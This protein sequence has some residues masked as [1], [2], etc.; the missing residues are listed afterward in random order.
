MKV[1]SFRTGQSIS[2][3][4]ISYKI[5]RVHESGS[6]QLERAKDLAI[7]ARSKSDLL[8]LLENGELE[9]LSGSNHGERNE[10][11]G[12][13]IEYDLS[14]F[15]K[16]QQRM[17][18][19]KY[20]YVIA[21]HRAKNGM[22]TATDLEE[23][24][25]AVAQKL[26]DSAPPTPNTVY[27]WWSKWLF[28]GQDIRCLVP[29]KKK[30]QYVYH[31]F[32]GSVEKIVFQVIEDEYLNREN[33]TLE[34]AYAELET[35]LKELNKARE[36]PLA[37]PSRATFFRIA[38]RI[39]RFDRMAAKKG[40]IAAEK[41]FR[42]T[43]K[44]VVTTSILER[45]E[46]DHTRLDVF[47]VDKVSGESI[48]RP[49]L[50]LLIDVHSRMIFGYYIG[51]EPPSELSVMLA[52]RNGIL[53][54]SNL[55]GRFPELVN[56]WNCY[57]IP[58]TLVSDN[59]MEFHSLQLRRMCAELNIEILFCPKKSP[60]YKG[61]VERVQGTLNREVCHVL[62]GTSFGS[63]GERGDYASQAMARVTLDELEE[64]I[65]QWIVDIYH[66][67]KHGTTKKPPAKVWDG[68]LAN[69][70]PMLPESRDALD[71]VLAKEWK[72]T[73][74]H[75]GIVFQGLRYNAED[76]LAIRTHPDFDGQV[77]IRVNPKNLG[78]IWV[79]DDLNGDCFKVYCT[80][81]EYANNLSLIQ[82]KL[83]RR[84]IQKTSASLVDEDYLMEAKRRF[85]DKVKLMKADK[86]T[87]NRTRAARYEE[88]MEEQR[89]ESCVK[90][91][92][93]SNTESALDLEM[94]Y[95]PDYEAL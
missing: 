12:A 16:E 94:D 22:R 81:F 66:Q 77:R 75:D 37:I 68:D 65:T 44:G 86:L 24:I 51:F 55:R 18:F 88:G 2:L 8:K 82:H 69:I 67:R 53:P 46:V 29:P 9:F 61:C 95:I 60:Q 19:R 34:S 14:C 64:L 10:N 26:D 71:L 59:A 83:I 42:T 28:A 6:Y 32:R 74:S 72:R 62:P 63:I 38:K 43:G 79:V 40:K 54:K 45:V 23:A 50:T 39:D 17:A 52:L 58:F 13:K 47:V 73:L 90:Q 11:F 7:V 85:R 76:L 21:V 70:E 30:I 48:G 5:I 3:Q 57:G 92:I 93:P 15:S 56:D 89:F 4:N 49:Y 25:A 35:R 41:H 80:T 27:R 84:N 91:A 33:T 1:S 87:K 31:K 36:R 20:A 78:F